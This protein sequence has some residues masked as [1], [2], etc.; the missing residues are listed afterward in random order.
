M[1]SG[2]WACVKE[3]FFYIAGVSKQAMPL[4]RSLRE[5]ATLLQN[6]KQCLEKERSHIWGEAE[7]I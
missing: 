2:S 1:N 3:G 4:L 5:Q 6:P 7:N